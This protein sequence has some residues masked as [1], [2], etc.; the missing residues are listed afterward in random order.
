M[1]KTGRSMIATDDNQRLAR[2]PCLRQLVQQHSQRCVEGLRFSQIVGDVFTNGW[3]VGEKG[4][5]LTYQSFWVDP[6]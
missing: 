4:G 5:E 6:P 3:H 2:Q 1:R